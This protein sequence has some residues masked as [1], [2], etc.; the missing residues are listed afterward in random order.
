MNEGCATYTHYRIMTTLHERGWITDGAFMEF[1]SS[2]TNVVYQHT[3]DSGQ[4]GGYNPYALGFGIMSDLERNCR[5]PTGEGRDWVP[6]IAGSGDQMV[7]HMMGVGD[8]R[9]RSGR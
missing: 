6:N 1:L 9:M 3:Y 5:E 8:G 4:F 7:V 2:H